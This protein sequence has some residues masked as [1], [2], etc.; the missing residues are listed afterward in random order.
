MHRKIFK[1]SQMVSIACNVHDSQVYQEHWALFRFPDVIRAPDVHRWQCGIGRCYQSRWVLG[2]IHHSKTTHN[3][4]QPSG[5]SQLF[6]S[7]IEFC[8]NIRYINSICGTTFLLN[9]R[10][11]A[12]IWLAIDT[13]F[14]MFHMEV[15]Y[16][17]YKYF[18]TRPRFGRQS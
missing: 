8:H 14:K 9:V 11:H 2:V 16:N 12:E 17:P 6:T 5:P 10:L 7:V 3:W 18:I 13:D 15:I 1:L 4:V